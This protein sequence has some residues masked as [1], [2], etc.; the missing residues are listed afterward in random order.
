MAVIKIIAVANFREYTEI[1]KLSQKS[2][3]KIIV[4]HLHSFLNVTYVLIFMVPRTDDLIVIKRRSVKVSLQGVLVSLFIVVADIQEKDTRK[5]ILFCLVL[6]G[7]MFLCFWTSVEVEHCW[8]PH[9]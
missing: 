8:S 4:T 1:S 7:F 3:S 6:A 5:Q 2:Y 9:H